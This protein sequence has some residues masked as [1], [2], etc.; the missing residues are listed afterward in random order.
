M[1]S[2][3]DEDDIRV[4]VKRWFVFNKKFCILSST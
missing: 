4:L 3:E 1:K 2:F